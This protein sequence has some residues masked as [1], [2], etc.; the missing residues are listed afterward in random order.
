MKTTTAISLIY[1]KK[2]F[3]SKQSSEASEI[4]AVTERDII[5]KKMFDESNRR[6]IRNRMIAI[7][8]AFTIL[9]GKRGAGNG[10]SVKI[11]Y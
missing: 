4:Q 3:H 11:N 1:F 6:I 7:D 5:R 8:I 9:A 2:I 10:K